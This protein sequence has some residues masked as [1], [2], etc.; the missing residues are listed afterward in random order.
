MVLIEKDPKPVEEYMVA[1]LMKT[2]D[3]QKLFFAPLYFDNY[4]LDFH[5]N[6]FFDNLFSH[7][8]DDFTN[9]PFL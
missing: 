9:P 1:E 3:L 2:K 5:S 4:G 6:L 8:V 7:F